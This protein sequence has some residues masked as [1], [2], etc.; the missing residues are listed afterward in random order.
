VERAEARAALLE[1]AR[2]AER[3]ARLL[4]EEPWPPAAVEEPAW[5]SPTRGLE[6]VVVAGEEDLE[7]A[8]RRGHQVL[9][10]DGSGSL[11]AVAWGGEER[12]RHLAVT[13]AGDVAL[14]AAHAGVQGSRGAVDAMLRRGFEALA[15]A[16]S[17]AG[18]RVPTAAFVAA[19]GRFS[20]LDARG[21]EWR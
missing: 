16:A 2:A 11:V 6:P 13:L 4:L 18:L 8:L 7:D 21:A 1:L 3:V 5:R 19:A 17:E 12:L 15:L 10:G 14:E 20:E 9:V